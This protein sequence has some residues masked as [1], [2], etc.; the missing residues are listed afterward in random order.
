MILCHGSLRQKKNGPQTSRKVKRPI[1]QIACEF[2]GGGIIH[3]AVGLEAVAYS[4]ACRN[5]V[6]YDRSRRISVS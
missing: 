1:H 2:L 6:A 3:F 5:T 4:F